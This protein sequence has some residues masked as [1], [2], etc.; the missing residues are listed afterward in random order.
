MWTKY[1]TTDNT[2]GSLHSYFDV[3]NS[4]FSLSENEITVENQTE[5][6]VE[7]EG[8]S[9]EAAPDSNETEGNRKK[10]GKYKSLNLFGLGKV[11]SDNDKT[12]EFCQDTGLLPKEV[13]CTNCG[14]TLTKIYK[15]NRRGR[16]RQQLCF[17]CNK[18]KCK[19]KK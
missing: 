18:Q 7:N 4:L 3:S 13:K 19:K 9:V 11:L 1:K 15:I 12:I 14:D 8:V 17:Q 6:P 5:R 16:K 10:R 2:E